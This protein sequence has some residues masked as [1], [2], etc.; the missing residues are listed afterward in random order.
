MDIFNK[1]KVKDLE[2]QIKLLKMPKIFCTPY[3]QPEP[4]K[5]FKVSDVRKLKYELNFPRKYNIGDIYKKVYKCV[6][7]VVNTATNI[8]TVIYNGCVTSSE[9]IIGRTYIFR[10]DNE[11]LEIFETVKQ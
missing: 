1:Q 6:N 4:P 11:R 3:K 7:V 2:N 5:V 8:D 10:K 9:V